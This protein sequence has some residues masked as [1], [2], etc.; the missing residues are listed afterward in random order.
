MQAV[1]KRLSANVPRYTSYSTAPRFHAGIDTACYAADLQHCPLRVAAP[2]NTGN[3]DLL[4]HESG[5]VFLTQ[6]QS[7]VDVSCHRPMYVRD[8]V[9]VLMRANTRPEKCHRTVVWL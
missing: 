5:G 2:E 6:L 1:S 9:C 7:A 4:R 3:E 8:R